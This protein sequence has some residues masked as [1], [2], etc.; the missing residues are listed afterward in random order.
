M[1]NIPIIFSF[2]F[3][4]HIIAQDTL[5]SYLTVTV[6]STGLFHLNSIFCTGTRIVLTIYGSHRIN[7]V[8]TPLEVS[9][10]DLKNIF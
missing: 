2:L 9:I 8:Q 5:I 7:D 4:V 6:T 3:L 1:Q 10:V